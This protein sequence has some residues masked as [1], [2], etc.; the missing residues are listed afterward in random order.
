MCSV[1]IPV[2]AM[3][4]QI[5]QPQPLE[6]KGKEVPVNVELIDVS[7]DIKNSTPHWI[8][9]AA[10][11]PEQEVVLD[12]IDEFRV[13][14]SEKEHMVEFMKQLWKKYP[15]EFEKEGN[16][17]HVNFDLENQDIKLTEDESIMLERI[18]VAIAEYQY[19]KVVSDTDMSPRW[20]LP[21]HWDIIY[22]PLRISP[23]RQPLQLHL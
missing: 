23:F 1:V 20:H 5:L 7:E 18:A 2:T 4:D 11:K 10:G 22:S 17:I 21:Q 8:L 12:W 9:L 6:E 16:F 3:Q 13:A 15:V 14:D 19:Q